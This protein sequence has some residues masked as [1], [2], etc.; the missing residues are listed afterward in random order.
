MPPMDSKYGPHCDLTDRRVQRLVEHWLKSGEVWWIHIGLPCT[1]WV[2]VGGNRDPLP[3]DRSLVSFTVRVLRLCRA[4]GIFATFENPP[5]SRVW[6]WPALERELPFLAFPKLLFDS[7]R[8]G[9]PF[10]KP[11]AIAG[12]LP[13]LGL[14]ALRCCCQGRHR[15]ELQGKVRHPTRGW[16]WR[17][18]LAGAYLPRWCRLLAAA[19]GP[20]AP[21]GAFGRSTRDDLQAWAHALASAAGAP[22]PR[23]VSAPICPQ[24]FRLPW[25]PGWATALDPRPRRC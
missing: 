13:G 10:K 17:T 5:A 7:C 14:L 11:G 25:R 12:S 22:E 18:T 19:A 2:P 3:A 4:R 15:V 23:G 24:R 6:R 16:T 9:A 8:F 20:D 1:R 21:R